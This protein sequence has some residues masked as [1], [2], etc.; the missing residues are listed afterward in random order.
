LIGQALQFR[1]IVV[2]ETSALLRLEKRLREESTNDPPSPSVG[3][4]IRFVHL[5]NFNP[6]SAIGDVDPD[7]REAISSI[8]LYT[9]GLQEFTLLNFIISRSQLMLI[10]RMSKSSLTSLHIHISP[11]SDGIFAIVNTLTSLRHLGISTAGGIWEHSLSHPLRGANIIDSSFY[12]ETCTDDALR[13]LSQCKFAQDGKLELAIPSLTPANTPLLRPLLLSHCFRELTLDVPSASLA[14]LIPDLKGVRRL[15][16]G[17]NIPPD[18]IMDLVPLLDKVGFILPAYCEDAGYQPR[19][20][21]FLIRLSQASLTW[22]KGKQTKVTIGLSNHSEFS[23]LQQEEQDEEEDDIEQDV[24]AFADRLAP[25]ATALLECGIV[26]VD[27]DGHDVSVR[28]TM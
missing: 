22:P 6:H 17:E 25:I 7:V 13:L 4:W 8:L 10:S 2:D 27:D 19:L 23:W 28:T 1:Q 12:L 18:S 20:M 16:F 5:E 26:I 11:A 3:R 15:N 9:D 14:T 24:R 21:D